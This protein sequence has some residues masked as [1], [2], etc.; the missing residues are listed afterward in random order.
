MATIREIAKVCGVS[1]ATVSNI[2]NGKGKCSAETEAKV[3]RVAREMHYRPNVMARNLKTKRS[4]SIGVIVEDMTIFSIP[5]IVDGITDYCEEM[6][7]QIL[8]VN[9]RLF[10]KYDDTY[11]HKDFFY[12]LVKREIS[13][14]V[15]KQVEGIIYVTAH[16][17]VMKECLPDDLDIPAAMAYGY[18]QSPKIPSVVVDDEDGAALIINELIRNGHKKIGIITG[19]EDS[20]HAQARLRGAQKAF[21]HAAI[22]YNPD[23]VKIGNWERSSGYEWT[24]ELLSGGVTAIFCMND[25]MAGGVYDRLDELGMTIGEGGISVAGYDDRMSSAYYKPAL[26]TVKLPLHDIGYEASRQVMK[27]LEEK[28]TGHPQEE[29]KPLVIQMPCTLVPRDSVGVCRDEN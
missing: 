12:D 21:Y 7:Y 14:L 13:D 17:R 9:L 26:S 4:R 10:K 23:F 8:L 24:D 16:E 15:N 22:P 29:Q 19:K 6:D 27:L 25:L 1:V 18:T 5:D 11:Y 28:Q 3:R 20:L 2:M